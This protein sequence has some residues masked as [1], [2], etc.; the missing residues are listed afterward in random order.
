MGFLEK[1]NTYSHKDSYPIMKIFGYNY[2]THYW[3][4]RQ[5][6][7]YQRCF[8]K[9]ADYFYDLAKIITILIHFGRVKRLRIYKMSRV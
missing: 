1:G 3:Y 4:V 9:I 2:A 5:P 7:V 8:D 6:S